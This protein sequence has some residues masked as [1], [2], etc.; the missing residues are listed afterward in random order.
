MKVP[1]I[2]TPRL[3]LR[4][5]RASDADALAKLNSNSEF[6]KYLGNGE[7]INSEDSWRVLAMF[8]GHWQLR[9]FGLWLVE[10]KDSEEFLGRVGLLEPEGWP[11]IEIGWGISPS[12]WGK[13]YAYEAASAALSWAFEELKVDSLISIIHPENHSSKRLAEKIGETYSHSQL[14]RQRTNDIYKISKVE[15]EQSNSSAGN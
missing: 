9:G 13:G 6:V 10:D 3:R 1:V 7:V 15:Y 8:A 2:E 12:C 5:W 4:G 11:G 14:V